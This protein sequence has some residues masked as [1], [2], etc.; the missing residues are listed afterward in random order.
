MARTRRYRLDVTQAAR[1]DVAAIVRWSW[2]SFGE[3]ASLRY[4]ALAN[5]ALDDLKTDPDRIGVQTQATPGGSFRTYYL[6]FSRKNV[7][8]IEAVQR[9]RHYFVYRVKGDLVEILRLVHDAQDLERHLPV[10]E[11]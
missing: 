6:K 3:A 9:P 5:Q 10:E 11:V 4:E 2:G 7:I 8:G 1:T